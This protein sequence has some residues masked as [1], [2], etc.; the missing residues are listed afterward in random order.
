MVK[1]KLQP[2]AN[3]N[4]ATYKKIASVKTVNGT[5]TK[6]GVEKNR[7]HEVG[8]L[9]STPHASQMVIK[10]HATAVSEPKLLSVYFDDGVKLRFEEQDEAPAE[11]DD[12]PN[13]DVI[14]F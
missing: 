6:D 10:L 4:M 8:V 5:Y 3:T 11:I 1:L 9:L 14:P 2:K 7:Y 13:M 12:A